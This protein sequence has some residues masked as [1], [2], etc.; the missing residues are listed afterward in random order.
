MAIVDMT[1]KHNKDPVTIEI[2]NVYSKIVDRL[3][4]IVTEAL[5][6]ALSFYV[7]GYQFSPAFKR[8]FWDVKE[9]KYKHWDGRKHLLYSGVGFN[10][11]LL[12]RVVEVLSTFGI[13]V[14]IVDKRKPVP[15]GK[16]IKYKGPELREYQV[17]ALQAFLDKQSG[18]EKLC[19]GAGKTHL[20]SAILCKT[21]VH[22]MVFVPSLDL[23]YQTKEVIEVDLG[24]EIGIIG[25]GL[26][27]IRSI[28]ISTIWSAANAMSKKALRFDEDDYGRKEKFQTKD[29]QRIAEAIGKMEMQVVDECHQTS[30]A[31]LQAISNAAKNCRYRVGLSGTPNKFTGEDLLIE[32]VFGRKII[33]IPASELIEKGFLVKPTIHFVEIQESNEDLGN[34]YQGIYKKF[35]VEN[36]VRNDRIIEMA[37]KLKAAGRKTLI[38]VKNIKHGESLMEK[39][40]PGTVVYF[41]RGELDS[42]ERNRIRNDFVKGKI[43]VIVASAV[44]DQGIDIANLDALILAGSGK[45][46]GRALQR[47]G[48]VIRP[49][50]DKKNAI[51]IDF[52]DNAKYLYNHSLKRMDVYKLEEGFEIKLPKDFNEGDYAAAKEKKKVRMPKKSGGSE[53][54]W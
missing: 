23:L 22:T 44:Y 32:G 43:D 14:V 25:D 20:L 40:D 5:D 48:R 19:T 24:K 47:I 12:E 31:S 4:V 30:C 54:P 45:S 3:P 38:L 2:G 13:K 34:N 18:I 7:E 36:E 29:K 10:T 50:K 33:D 46:S 15:Y 42:D 9:Q 51:V 53:V 52:I 16:E 17:R 35:I 8:G 11:G 1:I 41:V 39:F 26:C 6:D 28:T 21:N 27:D 49:A 37:N